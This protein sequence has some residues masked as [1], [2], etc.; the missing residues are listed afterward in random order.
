M[1]IN[2]YSPLIP[3]SGANRAM[4]AAAVSRNPRREPPAEG[5]GPAVLA[6]ISRSA[7]LMSRAVE[8]L[9]SEGEVRDE[10][11]EAAR[12]KLR[13]WPGLKEDQVDRIAQSLLDDLA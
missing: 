12:A 10:V 13:D 5:P 9:G 8:S 1:K 6:N 11:V 2:E 7:Q 4:S 3:V